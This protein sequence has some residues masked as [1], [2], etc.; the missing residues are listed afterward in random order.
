MIGCG[1][2]GTSIEE[3]AQKFPD[4]IITVPVDIR[5]G[6]TDAQANKMVDGLGVSVERKA[7]AEQIKSLYNLFAACDCTMVEVQPANLSPCIHLL[8]L[9][10]QFS[11]S[12]HLQHNSRLL[13]LC[14]FA[15][16]VPSL[17]QGIALGGQSDPEGP[18]GYAS[19]LV[20]F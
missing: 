17:G 7:A 11:E 16:L 14:A 5:E 18:I 12:C 1:E 2:G 9:H 8:A 15:R 19:E 20:N 3:L 4:K 6:I 13:V 10:P